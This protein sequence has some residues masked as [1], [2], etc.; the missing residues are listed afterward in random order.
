MRLAK[1][2]AFVKTINLSTILYSLGFNFNQ[3]R[4]FTKLFHE[5]IKSL[6]PAQLTLEKGQVFQVPLAYQEIHVLSGTAWITVAREDIIL[7]TG[8][9]ASLPSNHGFAVLSALGDVPLILK[10]C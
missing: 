8:K 10:V 1:T 6:V 7:T 3:L 2:H 5:P 9:K 4:T